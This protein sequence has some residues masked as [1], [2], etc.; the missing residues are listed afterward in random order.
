[1]TS[2]QR[3]KGIRYAAKSPETQCDRGQWKIPQL[4]CSGAASQFNSISRAAIDVSVNNDDRSKGNNQGEY[5]VIHLTTGHVCVS[6]CEGIW[7][8]HISSF[9]ELQCYI[10]GGGCMEK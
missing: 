8:C 7:I 10:R 6:V 4:R 9:A 5:I 2:Q 3:I 1:M